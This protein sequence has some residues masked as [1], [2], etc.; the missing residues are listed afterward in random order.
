MPA[1]YPVGDKKQILHV[2]VNGK[3][4]AVAKIKRDF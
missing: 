2:N 1:V 4:E 3:A